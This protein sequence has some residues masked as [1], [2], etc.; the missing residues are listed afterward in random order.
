MKTVS[1]LVEN[2]ILDYYC[3]KQAIFCDLEPMFDAYKQV[4][5]PMFHVQYYHQDRKYLQNNV[6][7]TENKLGVVGYLPGIDLF[8]LSVANSPLIL[9]CFGAR[10][11]FS[12]IFSSVFS[13]CKSRFSFLA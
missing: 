11:A 10:L 8:W 4:D 6:I 2:S 13:Y 7:Y 3:Y 9:I 12:W 1:L 5:V